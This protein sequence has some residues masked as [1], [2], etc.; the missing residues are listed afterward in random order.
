MEYEEYVSDSG[1]ESSQSEETYEKFKSKEFSGTEAERL[2]REELEITKQEF[3]F[4][5]FPTNFDDE[6]HSESYEQ[7]QAEEASA[8]DAETSLME[9]LEKDKRDFDFSFSTFLETNDGGGERQQQQQQQEEE[10][11]GIEISYDGKTSPSNV[12]D[13]VYDKSNDNSTGTAL[14]IETKRNTREIH[15]TFQEMEDTSSEAFDPFEPFEP[16]ENTEDIGV[17]HITFDYEFAIKEREKRKDKE[18][19]MQRQKE[20]EAQLAKPAFS[21]AGLIMGAVV[22]VVTLPET[23]ANMVFNDNGM[24]N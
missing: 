4:E 24:M 19:E 9:E 7:F 6:S 1:D 23:I 5:E 2:L 14:T 15:A 11:E 3:N 17:Q 21:F 22:E 13:D 16:F 12:V 8:K 18:K 10:E 20:K